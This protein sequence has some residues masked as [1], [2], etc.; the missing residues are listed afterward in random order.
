MKRDNESPQQLLT[1]KEAAKWLNVSPSLIYQLVEKG[2]LPHHRVGLGRGAI[3]ISVSDITE[4]LKK[5]RIEQTEGST[6]TQSKRPARKSLR[7]LRG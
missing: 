7:H 4:F 3:R 2:K 5:S 6:M 1:V